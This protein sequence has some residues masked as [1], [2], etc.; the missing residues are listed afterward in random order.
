[1]IL[2]DC[3]NFLQGAQSIRELFINLCNG[4]LVQLRKDNSLGLQ[5]IL[6]IYEFR[7]IRTALNSI[8]INEYGYLYD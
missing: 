7:D 3:K 4:K 1:M 6:Q 5:Q 2:L 8:S